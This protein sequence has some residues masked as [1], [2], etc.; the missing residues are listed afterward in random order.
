MTDA[1]EKPRYRV[2]AGREVLAEV[3]PAV[4]AEA[5][6]ERQ[7]GGYYGHEPNTFLAGF[8]PALRESQDVA[9]TSWEKQAARILFGFYNSGLI[10]GM[11]ESSTSMVVG[12]GL[13]MSARPD[14]K[15]LGWKPDFA[16]QFAEQFEAE[17][18]AWASN[19]YNCDAS[20]QLTFGQIQE[21]YHWSSL[22]YG[23]GLALMPYIDRPGSPWRTK[24]KLLPPSRIV[25]KSDG[26]NLVQGVRVDGWGMPQSYVLFEKDANGALV[27]REVQARDASGRPNVIH[28]F[29]ATIAATRNTAEL[30]A[31]MKSWR[32]YDQI[33]DATL[34][35]RMIQSVFAATMTS[36]LK[37]IAGFEGI[38]TQHDGGGDFLNLGG[39]AA[40]KGK[41]Y[42]GARL[43]LSQH[44]RI[45]HLFPGDELKFTEAS[46]EADDVD[47]V[48]R[49]LWLEVCAA[50]G[51]SYETGTGDYRG[52]TYSSVRM[53][54]AKEWQNVLRRR[55]GLISPLC[56]VAAEAVLEEAIATGRIS[57]PGGLAAYQQNKAAMANC[58][59]RGPRQPQA[60][61]F[62]TASA[63]QVRK[64]MGATTLETIF[65]DYGEDWD[66]ALEQQKRENDFAAA[67]G[68]PL[69]WSL[70][71]APAVA[72]TNPEE[73]EPGDNK[74]A[75]GGE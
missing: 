31:G 66:D 62:K 61:D 14:A 45:A 6:G 75:G 71:P 38:M 30:G 29:M 60:D 20:G 13:R 24:I 2:P 55:S 26:V 8:R 10:R 54:G 22:G 39:F 17:F 53:A 44:G 16:Q 69:P 41:W 3:L 5:A 40:E 74:P 42:D 65:A 52:A 50:I 25:N 1:A 51:I 4:S 18:Q 73:P 57:V 7:W 46:S 33:S 67:R 48:A 32:Q 21:A 15:A 49:W 56:Q 59:W 36:E 12:T 11:L 64:E 68:L 19:P 37:G 43:D 28:R 63:H 58:I 23:E 9:A 72:K 70:P 47:K 27:E 35:K 34:T